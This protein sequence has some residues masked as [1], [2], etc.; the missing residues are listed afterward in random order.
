ML[1]QRLLSFSLIGAEWVLWLIVA[2]SMVSLA[3]VADRLILYLRTR[4]RLVTLEPQLSAALARGDQAAALRLVSG[5]TLIRNVLRSGLEALAAGQRHPEAVE[6][7]MLAA[8]ARERVRYDARLPVLATIGN[9]APFVGLFGTVLGIIMAFHQLGQAGAAA[10]NSFVMAA[11]GE[12]L[13]A[14]AAGIL[15]AI[16]AVAAYNFAKSHVAGRA[17]QAESLMRSVLAGLRPPEASLATAAG[18]AAARAP[19][20]LAGAPQAGGASLPSAAVPAQAA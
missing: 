8:L 9:N 16:P 5:D 19:G 7:V 3:I 18:G 13:I 15:V 14:T 6:Q 1:S 12:A 20:S 2:L 17:K 4:E 11:I 10:A